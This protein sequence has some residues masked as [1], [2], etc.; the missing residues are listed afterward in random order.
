MSKGWETPVQVLYISPMEYGDNSSLDAMSHSIDYTLSQAGIEL[1]VAYADFR[2]EG[3]LPRT[4]DL[5][6]E[7]VTADVSAIV[8]YVIDPSEPADAVAYARAHGVRVI[9][10]E[11][12][13]FDVDASLVYPNFNHGIYMAEYLSRLLPLGARVGVVGG[14]GT[15]D[16]DELVLGIVHGV[17]L[18]GLTCVNDPE[19]PR[20]KNVTDVRAG[21]A[22]KTANLLADFPELDALVPYNDETALGAI[23]ALKAAARLGTM[24]TISRNGTPSLVQ[25]VK[26]GFH[27][28]TWDL[29]TLG[30]GRAVAE[31]AI[32]LLIDDE[33]LDGLCIASPIGYM[34]TRDRVHRWVPWE[35]R[36]QY[37]PLQKW[38]SLTAR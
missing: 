34:I 37:R 5:I 9:S 17:R 32:R 36:I 10:I 30:I 15:A 3:W 8:L 20:Y 19:D 27:D 23:D 16:D 24:R 13:R 2:A 14:P 28:G 25:L 6:R 31:L 12:P 4:E 33:D 11:R 7:C 18:Y 1:R 26:E 29:D 22:E 21:G 35:Q 38:Q